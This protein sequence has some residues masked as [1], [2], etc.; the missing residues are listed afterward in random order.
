MRPIYILFMMLHLNT[1][2]RI[3]KS[4]W[5]Y[6]NSPAKSAEENV[7]PDLMLVWAWS[8]HNAGIWG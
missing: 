3:E 7:F 4:T 2:I 8:N 6:C 1:N 5:E